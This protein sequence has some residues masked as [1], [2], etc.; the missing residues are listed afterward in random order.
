MPWSS[1]A[2]TDPTT[3]PSERSRQGGV[4]IIGGGLAGCEAAW[5]CAGR[6]V[7]VKLLEMKPKHFSPAHQN[8][9]LAELVCS[10]SLRSASPSSAVGLLKEELSALN[11]LIMEAAFA[12]RV[13]AGQA[14]AVDRA[15]FSRYVT[16]KIEANPYIELVSGAKADSL[17]IPR[18][19]RSPLIVAAGP[20]AADE[21]VQALRET[22][23]REFLHFYD[24]LAPIV[25]RDSLDMSKIF[26]GDRYEEPGRGSYL[27]CP[28]TA[29]ELD[30]FLSALLEADQT[31]A[32]KF[33]EARFFE[34][35]LPIEV[36]ARRGLRTLTFGPMKPVGLVDPKTGKLPAAVVQLRLENE[37]GTHCN[38]VGFQTRLTIPSQR[39][40]FRLIPGLEKAEFARYG[41]VHRNTYL[42]AP[43]VL[44]QFQR[45]VNR[46]DVFLAGQISGVEGYVESAA[47]GLWAGENAARQFLGLPLLVP[48]A[49]TAIGSLT[50]HLTKK[51]AKRVFEPSN[52]N[53]GLFP[54]IPPE[55]PKRLAAQFRLDR[56]RNSFQAFLK[57]ISDVQSE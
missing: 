7:N 34:G 19:A 22:I 42:D 27:N 57:E 56:A 25:T 3:S 17:D 23:G 31:E 50:N 16:D 8:G 32:R 48:P 11:S 15:A 51:N 13:P 37:A 33:E 28:F 46:P 6:R 54:P 55:T 18:P 41:A 10:N 26:V 29:E 45:L 36:M 5:R 24:A 12:A 30:V 35:C 2:T 47:Q 1:S 43:E 21:L 49:D 40:V 38:L 44:D 14:L 9:D 39:Q 52:V 53:F 20:L 4:V